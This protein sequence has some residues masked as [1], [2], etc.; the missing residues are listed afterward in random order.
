MI[1]SVF[2][3]MD[4]VL[5]DFIAGI[6]QRFDVEFGECFGYEGIGLDRGWEAIKWDLD[7]EFWSEIQPMP[8][9]YELVRWL[10]HEFTNVYVLTAAELISGHI[11]GKLMWLKI[12]FP[13]LVENMIVTKHKHLLARSTALL[14]DDYPPSI[15]A[16]RAHRGTAVQV[17]SRWKDRRATVERYNIFGAIEQATGLKYTPNDVPPYNS[18]VIDNR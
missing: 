6:E 9:A 5:A 15:K 13:Q 12:F 7:I 4:M 11:E 1:Q 3:D 18:G 2:I 14:L 8:W 10:E 16:W 17:P